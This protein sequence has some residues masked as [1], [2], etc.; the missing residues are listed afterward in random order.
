MPN[1]DPGL[2][3]DACEVCGRPTN[4]CVDDMGDAVCEECQKTDIKERS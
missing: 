3:T 2:D 4:G 1:D